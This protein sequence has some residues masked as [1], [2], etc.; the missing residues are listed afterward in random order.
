MLI[1]VF[2]AADR[3]Q[4]SSTEVDGGAMTSTRTHNTDKMDTEEGK[5]LRITFIIIYFYACVTGVF[6]SLSSLTLS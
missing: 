5:K 4:S 6:I 3:E 1:E 2:F